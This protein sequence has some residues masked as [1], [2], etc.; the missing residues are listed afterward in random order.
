[1]IYKYMYA[2][3][4]NIKLPNIILPLK[5]NIFIDVPYIRENAAPSNKPCNL[6]LGDQILKNNINGFN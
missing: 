2:C 5:L 4:L 6:I 1:M 3:I